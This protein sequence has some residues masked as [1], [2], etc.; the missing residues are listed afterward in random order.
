M[1]RN[2]PASIGD[3]G[4]V[5]DPGDPMCHGAAELVCHRCPACALEPGAALLRPHVAREAA[6]VRSLCTSNRRAA[7]RASARGKAHA[8]TETSTARNKIE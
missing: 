1:A 4:S 3:V 5:L 7:P 2:P 8:A 6:P